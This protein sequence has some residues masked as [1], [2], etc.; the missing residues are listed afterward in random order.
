MHRIF[1]GLSFPEVVA[2][3]LVQLQFGLEGARWLPEENFHMT[4]Q[5]VGDADRHGLAEIHLAL[6]DIVAPAF[7]LRL[8]GCGFFGDRKPRALWV[9]ADPAQAL[10]HLQSKVSTAL[11]RAGFPGEKRKYTPH[12]TIAY[13]GGVT[14][15]AAA[16]F[17]SMHGLFACG[18]FR[19]PEFHLFQSHL[20]GQGSHYEILE[21]YRLSSSR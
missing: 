1:I 21:T 11:A 6:A 7:D 14:Q 10:L 20:G 16:S 17:S 9:G 18:P 5:F 13:L 3:A 19:I 4:L 15:E 2:D 8:S 12:V